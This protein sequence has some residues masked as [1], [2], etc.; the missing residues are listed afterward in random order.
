MEI[1]V[2][3]LA[4]ALAGR[5]TDVV[6]HIQE[7][8]AT[9]QG[10]PGLHSSRFYQQRSDNSC[11]LLLH[12]WEDEESW[13][14]ARTQANPKTLLINTTSGMLLTQP[15]QWVMYYLW[16]YHRPTISP[17]TAS[18]HLTT[19]QAG[20]NE[21]Y[22]RGWIKG[23]QKQVLQSPV[24]FAFLAREFGTEQATTRASA[25]AERAQLSKPVFLNLFSWTSE[26]ER[27][28]FYNNSSYQLLDRF[29]RSQGAVR[30]IPLDPL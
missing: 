6:G 18:V 9:L 1:L 22:Q 2:A 8:N 16:G 14:Q 28:A 24:S 15:E 4:Y 10:A 11:F 13:Q 7:L 17:T 5:D 12:T 21:A 20:N 19:M 23:L 27:R 30:I 26:E 25:A 3:T 29:V